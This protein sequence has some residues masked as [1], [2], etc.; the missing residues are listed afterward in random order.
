MSREDHS[1]VGGS[2][3]SKADSSNE[4]Q[5]QI[6]YRLIEK[7]TESE[8][9]YR[10]LIET[11]R[12]IVFEC[13]ASGKF[14]LLNR[15]WTVTLGY[16]IQRSLGATPEEFLV[17]EDMAIW[18]QAMETSTDVK[19]LH[20]ELR[21]LHQDGK[22]VWLELSLTCK[23]HYGKK[24]FSGSLIDI[25]DRKKAASDLQSINTALESRVQQ[26]TQALT[27][28]NERLQT[29]LD[30][31][32]ETQDQLVQA[33]K[34]SSLGKLVG[35]LAHEINNPTHFIHGNMIHLERYC[36]DILKVIS[37]YQEHY[38]QPPLEI[39]D[40]IEETELDFLREDL[41]GIVQS[42]QKG[43]NHIS[44]IILSLQQFSKAST[45]NLYPID[46]NNEL[47][48]ALSIVNNRFDCDI[49]LAPY[50]VKVVRNYG[51]VPNIQGNAHYLSEA[52]IN[53]LSNA[54]ESF[55]NPT[56]ENS[57]VQD[58]APEDFHER[59]IVIETKS[60]DSQWIEVVIS[61]NGSGIPKKFQSRVF[62]PFFTTK[63]VGQGIGM[64]MAISYQIVTEHHQGQL[65]CQSEEGK[66]TKFIICLPAS[67]VQ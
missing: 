24:I 11:L 18:H 52:L 16:P 21:F 15:A 27:Q 22:I 20:S 2:P 7:L 13:D 41:P 53:I 57:I 33:E 12:E 46:I 8:Q 3:Q 49:G 40:A 39:E 19:G 36:R 29:A 64:G 23:L 47:E 6:H 14:T 37:L 55:E 35:G 5:T 65:T 58:S 44:R 28:S 61:D 59:K 25:T 56:V 17:S 45:I 50:K 30:E 9:R 66:G 10:H 32:K 63:P 67:D 60:A 1:K 51:K 43:A 34:M 54:I 62:D 42:V 4:L 26:R 31:L 38:P 48:N